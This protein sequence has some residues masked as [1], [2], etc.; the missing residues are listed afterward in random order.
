MSAEQDASGSLSVPVG[1][2]RVEVKSR[3]LFLKDGDTEDD[4]RRV[5]VAKKG[6]KVS[7][8]EPD[9]IIV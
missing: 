8:P 6:A 2:L 9:D 3:K 4:R 7:I 5:R 1:T